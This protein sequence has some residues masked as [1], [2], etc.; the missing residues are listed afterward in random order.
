MNFKKYFLFLLILLSS[1]LQSQI[2][3]PSGATIPFGSNT[4]YTGSVMFPTNLP[5]N[6]T[7]TQ[8]QDAADA[9]NQ[10]KT[11]YV[12]ACGV[13]KYRVKYDTPTETVSEGIAYG[14]LLAAY[15]AD[16]D[17]F[18]GLWQYYK[19]NSNGNGVMN[20]KINS[21]G[22][23]IGT[24]GAAD[25]EIDAA[26]ALLVANHQWPNNTTPHNYE[27]EATNLINAIKTVEIQPT[28]AN[29]SYQLNNG[30]QWGFGN[31]CR[32]P[33]YQAP[34]YFKQYGEF[35]NDIAFWDNCVSAS[36]TLLNNNVNS[37]TGLVSNWSDHNGIP[38][39][40]NGPNEYGWDACRNPWRMVTDVAWYDDTNAKN[41][42]NNMA[43]YV[44]NIGANN[45]A[46]PVAQSGGV[47]SNHSA[48]FV[49][50][51]ALGVMGANTSYQG[52]L[53]QMYTETVNTIDSP[54]WYF[55]NTL[56]CI[57]LFTMT[58]NF[59]NPLDAIS[60]PAI[61][62]IQIT[63]PQN[64]ANILLG[65]DI[66]LI[67]NVSD[68]D[69][70]ITNVSFT[71]NGQIVSYTQNGIFYSSTWTP[72]EIGTYIFEVSATD[73]EN[74]T[75]T[76]SVTF[77]ISDSNVP[78][79][80]A[81]N[82]NHAEV[83][84]K[85]IYFYEAQRSG[86][87]PTN[88]RVSWRGDSGMEDGADNNVDLTGGWYDAGDHVKFGF[89]MAY[90]ATML[91]WS[92]V[93]DQQ[94]YQTTNQWQYLKD[95]LKWVN[96]YFLKCHIR[97]PDGSTQRFYGQV[98][99]GSADHAWWGP[100]EVMP[101][102]RPSYY[103]D[104]NN[105]GTDLTAETAAALAAASIIFVNDDPIY[106]AE[107]LDNAIALYNFADTYRG[108]YSDAISD[109]TAFY[110][111]WSGY[112]DELVW[113]AIWLYRAT[114]DIAYLNKA[115]AD[116]AHLGTEQSGEKSWHWTIAWDDKSYGAYVLM[117]ELTGQTQ[118]MQDAERWL[119]YWSDGYNG[120]QI[121]YSPGGQAHLDT[122]GS[123]RYA[124][125]T[126][127]VAMVYAD[128]IAPTNPTKSATYRDFGIGQINYIL[129]DNP[130]NRSYIIGFGNNPPINP[131]HRTAHGS[132]ANSIQTPTDNRHILCG[133][134]VGGPSSPN[135]QYTDDRSDYIANE[136]ACDY[137]A[138]FT[139]AIA[140]MVTLF[141]GTPLANFPIEETP[142]GEYY[143]N[144]KVNSIGN[145]FTEIAVWATNHSAWP[146]QVTD[147]MCFRYYVD[148]SEGFN[149]G[150]TI[151][152]YT[153]SLNTAP[154]GTTISPLTLCGG[155]E[156]YVEVCY[157][158]I[159][160]YPGGQSESH[161]EAQIRIALPN[162]APTS[163]W[164]PNNDWSY[165]NM[166]NNLSPN[167]HIPLY[168]NGQLL[169]GSLPSCDNGNNAPVAC[170]TTTP[171]SG[172]AP[173]T[174]NLNASCSSDAD[175]DILSY[176]WDLG[177]G[178]TGTSAILS[179]TY[180]TPGIYTIMLTI[181]DGNG[182]ISSETIN[183]TVIDNSPQ[184]PTAAISANPISGGSPLTVNFD[185]TNSTDPNGD[186]LSYTWDF[187]DGNTGIGAIPIHT[188][189]NIGTY[190]VTVNVDDGNGGIDQATITINVINSTPEACFTT[191]TTTGNAPLSIN[192]DANCST[193][194]D[195]DILSYTW[196]FGDGNTG[197]GATTSYSYIDPG[198]YQVTLTTNDGNGGT[199][200]ETIT[201][202]IIDNTP[203]PPTACF[204]ANPTNG[205]IPLN[206]NFNASCSTDPNNDNL[207]YTWDFGDGNT[208]SGV[209][210][211]HNFTTTGTFIVSLTV[212][213]GNGGSDTQTITI[214]TQDNNSNNSSPTAGIVANPTNGVAPLLVNFSAGNSS[215]PDGDILSYTW[216]FGD[217]NTG[218]NL[219]ASNTY[220]APGTYTVTLTVND[221]NGGI[222]TA[223]ITIIVQPGTGNQYPTASINA[224]P[225][226]GNSPLT[227]NFDG[228]NSSDPDGDNLSYAWDFGDGNTANGV[229]T[230]HTY[231]IGGTYTATLTVDD[232]NGGTSQA[233]VNIEVN[234]V[235]DIPIACFSATP[236]SGTVPLVVSFDAS[237]SSDPNGDNLTYT[238]DFG[239]GNTG[240]G[241]NPNHT[242]NDEGTYT[243]TLTVDDGNNGTH[244]YTMDIDV[245]VANT[246]LIP[247]ACFSATPT[248]GVAPLLVTLDA[249]C[250]T[251]PNGDN[252]TY[253]WDFGDGNAGTGMNINHTYSNTGSYIITLIV[254]DG[255]GGID[256]FTTIINIGNTAT[257]D[258]KVYYRTYDLNATDNQIRPH[259]QIENNGTENIPLS[260][261]TIR[262]WYSK[263][264][265]EAENAWVDYAT[266]GNN[267]ITTNFYPMN[268]PTLDANYYFELGFTANAGTLASN[269]NTGEIQTRFAKT[270][271]SNY[272]ENDDYSYDPSKSTFECWERVTLYRNGNLI[273][274]ME[275]SGNTSLPNQI[276]LANIVAN[277]LNGI[278]PLTVNFN[279][280]NSTDP[281]GDP[282]SYTWNFG[283][284][285]TATGINTSHIYTTAGS[286]TATLIVDDGNGGSD[287]VTISINVQNGTT[288]QVPIAIINANPNNGTEPLVVN[289]NASNSSDPDGDNLSY[290]WDFGDGTTATGENISHTYLN[291]GN[292]NVVLVVSDGNGG[293]DTE[294]TV[295]IVQSSTANQLPVAV[296]NATPIA[297]LSPLTVNFDANGSSDPDGDNLSYTWDFGD[298][299]TSNGITIQHIY[300]L[301]GI[302]TATLTV[303][304]NNGGVSTQSI[305]IDVQETTTPINQ[306]LDVEM[307]ITSY[308]QSGLCANIHITNIGTTVINNWTISFNI[309]G[310][311]NNLWN[312]HWSG[313]QTNGY[314]ASDMGWNGTI[315]P[316]ETITIGFCASHDGSFPPPSSA[317]A[318]GENIS[319]RLT[320]NVDD[321]T[322]P[323]SNI[324]TD[325]T[326]INILVYPSVNDGKFNLGLTNNI[327]SSY[328]LNLF[329]TEGK[330]MKTLIEE[331]SY[332][333]GQIL[334]FDLNLLPGVY[335]IHLSSKEGISGIVKIVVMR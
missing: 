100:A 175:G 112:N 49:S 111:S 6:G 159:D 268:N 257:G 211:N 8:A 102:N 106:S 37:N 312:A 279:A 206:S 39:S 122:W 195:G 209:N 130:Q 316:G 188:Y 333:I 168:N 269:S 239:D 176:T 137:N 234:A 185:A 223:T 287:Q 88:N 214:T 18:D 154:N 28:W 258:L 124:A 226:S 174:I 95:N 16:K 132:W 204:T 9:Y 156:Y 158:N 27:A 1:K 129:G 173:L 29:G 199:D 134:L 60:G 114:G 203:Q 283:D 295:I 308:W 256:N 86:A 184:P 260:E 81:S 54:P 19:D 277:P 219:N 180:T 243:V 126:A 215:D 319:M 181:D 267:N 155:T 143:S 121:N 104:S 22:G 169:Y 56:R 67:A 322:V 98:G 303:S 133:A 198:T 289:F 113:G 314:T 179:E 241:I 65:N 148:L 91:A 34:A 4:S 290:T 160:I 141:G 11:N 64:A 220:T 41:I 171:L 310:D 325:N 43:S 110:N 79:P 233:T 164:D 245:Q 221:G 14:M 103:V 51:F 50:T 301:P 249:N 253:T 108:K 70:T 45:I 149:A 138:G 46:G 165:N 38:N 286:Y 72:T 315:N 42:C 276:P 236:T 321:N 187:G 162:D 191:S 55:G 324:L 120:Q 166:N 144:A 250:S 318:N 331:P 140:R 317:Q 170:F 2:N 259:F 7:Y 273:F 200:V 248:S 118:Y 281:D 125:N 62:S 244:I 328:T 84:Q 74:Q 82:Y 190:I 26:M 230:T 145:T 115:I 99:N 311:I 270:N 307:E 69:G 285:N 163:A 153:I 151:N 23:A 63:S 85:S 61:P 238:W 97:N 157:S 294:T 75:S 300:T 116:Y 292:Y 182:S 291:T 293:I 161:K 58:G 73:N 107:L 123:L 139:G 105:P 213:D 48:T 332:S 212:D 57:S 94:A 275:P 288:N 264:G 225:T 251:D 246:N 35:M 298:G 284:G 302:Y 280:N 197:T 147:Q 240:T 167:D 237:C 189:T 36:Y 17:L 222:T 304:D 150:Y 186:N 192:F 135:D 232:G 66:N 327:N 80:I 119:D 53:D 334:N 255:N 194:T 44:Q 335:F 24:G 178:N 33:S 313:S 330:W 92:G 247:T 297:G 320:Y 227:V 254:N 71:I 40:C 326:K 117:A 217:G 299:T 136:V 265:N 218:S 278:A 228:N 5:T 263:E 131:H 242:F 25:A 272:N 208:G 207:T 229:S 146:A 83:L 52:L 21:C 231:T 172:D 201:I 261:L 12:E 20:W 205:T 296:I 77:T 128:V 93:Q 31:N 216:D 47:G 127:F 282:L 87:L 32:N 210:I 224:T 59:W 329:N 202:T 252:L 266:L 13:G 15:A 274:G 89:P 152:D 90:T 101:M 306:D 193:D 196:D 177:N 109:A 96:D 309:E 142:S 68:S 235:N 3:T 30:D 271:W 262:Y 78:P 76:Q 305:V 183:I 323:I 10:W